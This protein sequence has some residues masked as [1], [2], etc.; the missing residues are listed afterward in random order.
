MGTSSENSMAFGFNK[1]TTDDDKQKTNNVQMPVE[2]KTTTDLGDPK[3]EVEKDDLDDE[4]VDKRSITIALVENYS[5][6][7]KVNE[8]ALQKRRDYIGS[9][10][11]ASRILSSNKFEI[12]T[13]FPT[14]LGY[15]PNHESFIPRLKQYLNNIKIHVDELGR[16]FDTSFRYNHKRDYLKV[17]AQEDKIEAVYQAANRQDL[18]SLKKALQDKITALNALESSKCKYGEPVNLEDYLMYRH[19]LLYKDVAKDTALINS[20]KTI[21]FYFRDDQKEAR[22][23]EKYRAEVNKAK[24]NFVA[25]LTDDALFDAIY[26]QYCNY[27]N[28]PIMSSLAEDRISK[29][30]KLD[31]FSAD[32]PVKFN[33]IF[34]NKDVKLMATIELLIARGE[35]IRYRDNQN[36]MTV[37]GE[38]IGANIGEAV[39]WFKNPNNTSVVNAYYNKLKNI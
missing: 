36:I 20:D 6:Y 21:R 2:E 17:R 18:E 5:L 22:K 13:Y 9:S 14:L 3:E 12:E 23:L 38:L 39:A 29:E 10:V 11:T 30:V 26:I 24:A 16:T 1:P 25:C 7:R 33:K 27:Q 34:N 19:C 31:K 4:F 28:L 32:N 15:P 35:L 37:D 8:R